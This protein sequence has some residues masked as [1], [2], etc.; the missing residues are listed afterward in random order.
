MNNTIKKALII[1]DVQKGFLDPKWA[2]WGKRNN[3][4]AE[5]KISLLLEKWRKENS[6][7]IHVQHLSTEKDSPLHTKEGQV[8]KEEVTPLANEKI[9][10]KNVNSAFIGTDLEDYL[11]ENKIFHLVIVGLTTEHCVSTTTRM[12]GNLGFS[13]ELVAD[14][15]ATFH[16]KGCLSGEIFNAE[17]VH[18]VSLSNLHEEFCT[19]VQTQDL[20]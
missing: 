2:K 11:R 18:E 5:Q 4:D 6:P 19:V 7:I 14:A 10:Q 8:F 16:K 13:V 12:A 15:T 17:V 20:L 9:V 3:P 1:I